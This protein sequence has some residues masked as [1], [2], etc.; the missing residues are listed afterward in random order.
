[1]TAEGDKYL[2]GLS[3]HLQS[4]HL[5]Q[6]FVQCIYC[7]PAESLLWVSEEEGNAAID[8]SMVRYKT[9]VAG[10]KKEQTTLFLKKIVQHQSSHNCWMCTMCSNTGASHHGAD[11]RTICH[12]ILC[13]FLAIEGS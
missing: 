7:S 4:L 12:Q 2:R 3:P 10:R 11:L 5:L 13:L 6:T 1:M 9:K 8:L